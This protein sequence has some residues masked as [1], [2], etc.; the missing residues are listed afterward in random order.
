MFFQLLIMMNPHEF[1]FN[2]VIFS[3]NI[4][5]GMMCDIMLKFPK[6]DIPSQKMQCIGKHGIQILL[7]ENELCPASCIILKP[8]AARLIPNKA[9]SNI[10]MDQ[11]G[12]TKTKT[13][14]KSA[15][16]ANSTAALINMRLFPVFFL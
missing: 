12:C 13:V 10:L 7:S 3:L 9:Q 6:V 16:A 14:Y 11:C 5:I 15:K 8:I 1:N 2:V 4:G